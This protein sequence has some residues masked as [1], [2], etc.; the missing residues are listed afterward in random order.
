MNPS[1]TRS[2]SFVVMTALVLSAPAT[3][4]DGLI[5]INQA[6]VL[7]G[8]VTAGDAPGYPATLTGPGSY[9]LTGGLTPPAGQS[10][11]VISG[12]Q[13]T[14]DLNGFSI[15][16]TA[17]CTGDPASSC[18]AHGGDGIRHLGTGESDIAIHGGMIQ[19]MDR[20]INVQ[21]SGATIAQITAS[22]NQLVGIIGARF[23]TVEGSRSHANG[24][25]GIFVDEQS[26]VTDNEVH[27][28]GGTGIA[29]GVGSIV[30]RNRAF[31][32]W[33]A[34]ISATAP[35]LVSQNLV[36]LNNLSQTLSL[37]G[38][39]AQSF[40]ANLVRVVDNVLAVNGQGDL[41][42]PALSSSGTNICTN[43]AC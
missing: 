29:A 43:V 34:G 8:G 23:S 38:I 18:S 7:A 1:K 39:F 20:G 31:S 14:L 26:R 32:N 22:R 6:S 21:A 4:D 5:E 16:G 12:S 40:G 41:R 19:G 15:R 13:V 33:F 24:S 28:N 2:M 27:S 17:V 35:G 9:R 42:G 30:S 37:G 3:A 10:G 36:R 11:I 25:D